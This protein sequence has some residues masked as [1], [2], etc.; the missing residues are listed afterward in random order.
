MPVTHHTESET[1]RTHSPRTD[2]YEDSS[3]PGDGEARVS[4]ED[5]MYAGEQE[6]AADTVVAPAEDVSPVP[7]ADPDVDQELPEQSTGWAD[8][9]QATDQ[10][11][12]RLTGDGAAQLFESEE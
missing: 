2:S 3:V 7:G 4:T 5:L 11:T 8:T 12:G 6:R 1:S 9:P 10:P